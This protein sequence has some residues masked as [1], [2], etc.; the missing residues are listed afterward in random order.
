[1]VSVGRNKK[2]GSTLKKGFMGSSKDYFD[3]SISPTNTHSPKGEKS[4]KNRK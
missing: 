2:M 1:M 4:M 3:T